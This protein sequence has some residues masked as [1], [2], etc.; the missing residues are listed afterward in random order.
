VGGGVGGTGVGA[1]MQLLEAV[2]SPPVHVLWQD[3][4]NPS[5]KNDACTQEQV[6][7]RL[8]VLLHEMVPWLVRALWQIAPCHEGRWDF[9][10]LPQFVAQTWLQ[11]HEPFSLNDSTTSNT[12]PAGQVGCGVGG[13]VAGIRGSSVGQQ[14]QSSLPLSSS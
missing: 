14:L 3:G 8:M 1:G 4:P 5:Q 6:M 9:T 11:S 13:G 12:W 7:S 2:G 10:A